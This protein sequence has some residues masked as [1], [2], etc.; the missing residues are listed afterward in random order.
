MGSLCRFPAPP[1]QQQLLPSFG[2]SQAPSPPGSPCWQQSSYGK[3]YCRANNNNKPSHLCDEGLSSGGMRLGT[4]RFVFGARCVRRNPPPLSQLVQAGTTI[5]THT[6]P[7][8]FQTLH[9]SSHTPTKPCPSWGLCTRSSPPHPGPCPECSSSRY[10]HRSVFS[11]LWSNKCTRLKRPCLTL[12]YK[13]A[14]HPR[15]PHPLIT[16]GNT[17]HLHV[18]G[19]ALILCI[20]MPVVAS[21]SSPHSPP[22]GAPGQVAKVTLNVEKTTCV[23]CGISGP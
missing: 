18:H 8:P 22:P 23:P 19:S 14:P 15:I 13:V 2:T 11:G 21:G 3:N 9:Q 10:M 17:T 16:A 6:P 5:F 12:L 20:M 4:R 1:H 7:T